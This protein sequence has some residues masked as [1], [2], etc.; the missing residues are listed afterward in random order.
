M[1]RMIFVSPM[2]CVRLVV[3]GLTDRWGREMKILTLDGRNWMLVTVCTI[4][5]TKPW[6]ETGVARAGRQTAL[7][8]VDSKS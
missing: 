5:N 7:L 6:L 1:Q 4:Y 2:S 8:L 3:T